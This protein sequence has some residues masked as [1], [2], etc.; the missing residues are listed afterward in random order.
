MNCIL[1]IEFI[2]FMNS[3][4]VNDADADADY[5]RSLEARHR[6]LALKNQGKETKE[7]FKRSDF[8]LTMLFLRTYFT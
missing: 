1:T 5:E 8:T 7:S 2:Y 6:M 3:K 4:K